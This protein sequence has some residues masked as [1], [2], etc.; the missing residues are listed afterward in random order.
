MSISLNRPEAKE[1]ALEALRIATVQKTRPGRYIAGL[2]V[3]LASH[4]SIDNWV[5]Q[6]EAADAYCWSLLAE[7]MAANLDQL[8]PASLAR[9]RTEAELRPLRWR[10]ALRQVIARGARA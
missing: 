9:V 8:G 4:E 5:P 7:E 1:Q 2:L 10:S 6:G 3:R